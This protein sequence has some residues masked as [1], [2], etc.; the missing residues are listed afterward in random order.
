MGF[1][2]RFTEEAREDLSRLYDW[3]LQR[4]ESDFTVAEHALQAVRDGITVLELAPL[5]CRKAGPDDPFLRELVI[6]FSAS[7]YV[8]LFEVE[9]RQ[10]VTVLAVRH[11]R[12]DDY[13]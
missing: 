11:Q 7:G 3:L 13:H 9:D 8:L 4:A 1:T 12:E 6:G 10:C 2:V 5:S